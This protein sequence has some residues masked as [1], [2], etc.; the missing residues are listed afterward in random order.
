MS[1]ALDQ[2]FSSVSNGVI[3]F[4]VAVAAS[5]DE[6]GQITILMTFLFVVLAALRGG[7]GILLLQSANQPAEEIRR[8]G[9]LAVFWAFALTPV[10]AITML[11]FIPSIGYAAVALAVF[12][13]FVLAQ[14]VLRYVAMTIGRP[15]IAAVWDGIWCLG[16]FI[17]LACAW[18]RLPFVSAAS[19]LGW[20]GL[21][22]LVAF[23][24][25]TASLRVLPHRRG[26]LEWLKNDWPHRVRFTIDA[27]LE[28]T[29]LLIIFVLMSFFMGAASTGALRGAMALFA[30]IGII[31]AAVQ[32]V[33]IPESARSSATARQIWR[34]LTPLTVYTA[35]FT[36]AIGIALHFVP[37][38]IGFYLLGESWGSAHA[39]LIP[40]TAWFTAACLSVVQALFLRTL[41][42]SREVLG[43]GVTLMITKLIAA[44]IASA[45][46][47]TTWAVAAALTIQTIAVA[48][49]FLFYW[50]PWRAEKRVD[51][52]EPNAPEILVEDPVSPAELPVVV[53]VPHGDDRRP[54]SVAAIRDGLVGTTWRRVDVVDETGSTNADLL[55]RTRAGEDIDGVVL[56]AEHQTAGRGR[57]GRQWVTTPRSQLALSVGVGA[58]GVPTERWGWLTLATGLA[59][60]DAVGGQP[61]VRATLKW[62]NDVLVDGAK[63]AG[64]LAEVASSNPVIVVGIG[65][66][67]TLDRA[68]SEQFNAT[69][70][71]DLGVESPDRDAL[72]RRLLLALAERIGQWRSGADARLS[73]DYRA[74]SATLGASVRVTLPGDSEV[75]GTALAVDDQGRLVVDSGGAQRPVSAGDVVHL[76][77]AEA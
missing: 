21:L 15:Q 51:T 76:R 56:I 17:A 45:W 62:P 26:A 27:A 43:Y 29:S 55:A 23:L 77:P 8:S 31:G 70:L 47:G 40:T 63:L 9:S 3:V 59:V 58:A 66:N 34:T 16:A 57:L 30:P 52:S 48:T 72:A 32:I 22:G 33:L 53:E 10:L 25:M 60:V 75:V 67:V 12:T 24:A 36:A 28:Q 4:A 5:P 38:K 44:A 11:A 7:L 64:I 37:P 20:W 35:M 6:F 71:R 68:E 39:V 46:F 19:V 14:D 1:G 49:F 13:P 41:N 69:S 61:G 65:L 2:A 42:L 73:A 18:L 74:H 50:P 54:L